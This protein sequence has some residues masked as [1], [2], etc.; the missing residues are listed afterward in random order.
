MGDHDSRSVLAMSRKAMFAR[1]G[2]EKA[3]PFGI[4]VVLGFSTNKTATSYVGR[5]AL[6]YSEAG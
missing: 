4:G 6:A 1:K 5:R 3:A 2:L